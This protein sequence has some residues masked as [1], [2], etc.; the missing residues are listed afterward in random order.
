MVA[1]V[2]SRCVLNTGDPENPRVCLLHFI[3]HNV[4]QRFDLILRYWLA[5]VKIPWCMKELLLL[6]TDGLR[7]RLLESEVALDVQK[8]YWIMNHP[9]V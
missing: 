7:R 1:A 9:Y 8:N 3:K 6:C 2:F 4:K 5:A